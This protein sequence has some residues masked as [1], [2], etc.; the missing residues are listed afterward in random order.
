MYSKPPFAILHCLSGLSSGTIL[1]SLGFFCCFYH[2]KLYYLAL[3]EYSCR[4]LVPE[5]NT[6][7]AVWVKKPT[8]L[9]IDHFGAVAGD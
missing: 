2:S 1:N 6:T 7:L 8:I 4:R 3:A 9:T 5:E